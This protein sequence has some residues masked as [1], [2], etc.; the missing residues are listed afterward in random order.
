MSGVWTL[1]EFREDRINSVS[2]ELLAWGRSLAD[3]LKVELSSVILGCEIKD[4]ESLFDHGS[5][6]V[7]KVDDKRVEHFLPDTYSNIIFSLVKKYDPQIIIASATTYGRTIMPVLSTKLNTGLTADCTKLEIGDDGTLLQTR[8][9]IG[10]NV[11]ATIRTQT[12][13][14]MAT[15]RP[16]S[17]KPISYDKSQRKIIVPEIED[18]L[19]KSAYRWIKFER[20]ESTDLPI[21]EA[22]V[23]ISGGRGMRDEKNFEMLYAL[24]K[25]LNGVVGA[26]RTAVDMGWI[27]YSHQ[28]GLSGKTVS[29]HLYMAFGISGAIQHI[30]GMSSSDIVIAVNTD[31]DAPIF[32]VADFG[33]VGDA[34]E[35]LPELLKALGDKNE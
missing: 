9:A 15:V 4:V 13:L 19:F 10:G 21:Q 22:D 29:P 27:P 12:R 18:E 33:I 20:D 34:T 6:I 26:S 24:A 17:K 3:T 16:R 35:I 28:V 5:D 32:N 25:E 8:P 14:Q 30:A 11:M 1:A 23:V 31:P 2:Y 7:Y